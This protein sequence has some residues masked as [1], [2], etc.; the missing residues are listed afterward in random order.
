MNRMH[1]QDR[2]RDVAWAME[3]FEQAEYAYVGGET[4]R[5]ASLIM[6]R[7]VWYAWATPSISTPPWTARRWTYSGGTGAYA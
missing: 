7:F 4:G 2:Y 5:T 3:Q 6:S 1:L